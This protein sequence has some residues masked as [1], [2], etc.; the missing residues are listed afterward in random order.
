MDG[1]GSRSSM[2]SR[3]RIVRALMALPLCNYNL[4]PMIQQNG[5]DDDNHN[6]NHDDE[7]N[8]DDDVVDDITDQESPAPLLL[9]PN[10]CL[11]YRQ[12]LQP[13]LKRE[14]GYTQ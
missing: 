13:F 4:I 12:R 2:W 5:R 7:M 3:L 6:E 9:N 8:D 1:S 14:F 10:Q 11:W